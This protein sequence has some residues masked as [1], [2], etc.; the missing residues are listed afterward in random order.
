MVPLPRP[1]AEVAAVAKRD[2]A[3]GERLDQIG[4]YCYRAWIMTAPEAAMAGA[5]P[6]GMLAGAQV[7]NPVRKGA[8]LT[9]ADIAVPADSALA[10][11]RAQQD[12]LWQDD[13]KGGAAA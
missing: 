9:R 12:A 13:G 10:R 6:C 11:I 1:V 2:L 3:P 5:V 8:L 7:L 4:E